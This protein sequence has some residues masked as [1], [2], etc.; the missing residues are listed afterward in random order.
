MNQN[1][2]NIEKIALVEKYTVSEKVKEMYKVLIKQ[3]KFIFNKLFSIKQHDR[4]EVVTAFSGLLEMS[5]RN[6][7]NTNQEEIF[8]DILV[9][10]KK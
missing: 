9:E 10:E 1:A 2:K 4:Q 5:R 3:K 7:V 8:G 6:K